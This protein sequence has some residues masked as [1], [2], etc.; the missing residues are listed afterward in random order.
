MCGAWGMRGQ[1]GD[2]WAVMVKDDVDCERMYARVRVFSASMNVHTA[3]AVFV[4]WRIV[5][6]TLAFGFYG[7]LLLLLCFCCCC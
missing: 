5:V 2:V 4:P 6:F 1:M 3:C 7:L